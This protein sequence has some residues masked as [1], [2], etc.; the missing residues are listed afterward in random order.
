M[1]SCITWTCQALLNCIRKGGY[2]E[3]WCL[4]IHC[5]RSTCISECYHLFCSIW[6][7]WKNSSA[8]RREKMQDTAHP[9]DPV[10]HLH[11]APGCELLC[12]SCIW[13]RECLWGFVYCPTTLHSF[14]TWTWLQ[15]PAFRTLRTCDPP[16]R[17]WRLI[18]HGGKARSPFIKT[19]AHW[20][21]AAQLPVSASSV[22][23]EGS[24]L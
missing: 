18:L 2:L 14:C 1:H 20:W 12:W 10:C 16:Q 15:T 3:N 9:K 8:H 24:I 5:L 23:L 7:S 6:S 19:K 17:C 11:D 4:L 21:P 22:V 13:H